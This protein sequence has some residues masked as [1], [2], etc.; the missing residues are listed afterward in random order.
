MTF[1][2]SRRGV[3]ALVAVVVIA[4]A[5]AAAYAFFTSSGSG[6]GTASVGA[7]TSFTVNGSTAGTLYPGGSVPVTLHVTN[8]GSGH[9][10]IGSNV[11]LQHLRACANG[12]TWSGTYAG[13]SCSTSEVGSCEDFDPGN[14]PNVHASDFYLADVT[15]ITDYAPGGPYDFA[16]GNLAMNDLSSSQDACKSVGLTLFF[17]TR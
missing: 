7:D 15:D 16:G 17:A 12:G 10:V 14:A 6:T 2:K 4:V 5:A 13:G 1:I 8:N 9:Q 11:Y 3:V